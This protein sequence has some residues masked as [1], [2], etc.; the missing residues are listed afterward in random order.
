MHH[1]WKT[2]YL[3]ELSPEFVEVFRDRAVQAT[4]PLSYSVIFHVGGALNERTQPMTAPSAIATRSS[5][6]DS[7]PSGRT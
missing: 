3:P 5:S 1:Y 2:E 4:S 6:A 7:P